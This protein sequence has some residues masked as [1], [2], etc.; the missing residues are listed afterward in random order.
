MQDNPVAYVNVNG[1]IEAFG[2]NYNPEEWRLFIDSSSVSLKTLLL[3]VGK[4]FRSIPIQYV[5][6]V[7]MKESH[8]NMKLLLEAIKC[9]DF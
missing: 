8:E 7:H 2:I 5:Y 4:E 6:T 9:G 1:L 3:H